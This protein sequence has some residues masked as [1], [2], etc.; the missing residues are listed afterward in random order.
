MPREALEIVRLGPTWERALGDFF[1]DLLA[2]GDEAFFHPHPLDRTEAKRL[3]NYR[4]RDLYFILTAGES[5]LGYGMLRGWDEG[6]DIPTLGL[7]I[8]PSVRGKGYGSA[9]A[10]FLNLAA[11]H[12]GATRLMLKA[13]KDNKAILAL[14]R[15]R[16]YT[17]ERQGEDLF[18]GML[19]LK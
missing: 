14:A 7:V 18:I 4:G 17:L 3:A 15:Q 8:H 9:L 11:R 1:E 5:V 19:D 6:F 12:Q 13:N 10:T 16:G 2:A